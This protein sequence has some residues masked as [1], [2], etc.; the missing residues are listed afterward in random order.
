MATLDAPLP[1]TPWDHPSWGEG[2][3]VS[4]RLTDRGVEFRKITRDKKLSTGGRAGEPPS[5][6]LSL[7]ARRAR[8]PARAPAG[9]PA[10]RRWYSPPMG[11]A[12]PE[13]IYETQRHVG[14]ALK[15]LAH[16]CRGGERMSGQRCGQAFAQ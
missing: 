2:R 12:S 5:P 7:L 6:P 11:D 16:E 14:W 9:G 3:V 13:E 4:R 15:T 1:L 10:A 8:A